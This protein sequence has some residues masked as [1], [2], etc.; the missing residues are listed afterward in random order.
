MSKIDREYYWNLPK[1][2]D[3]FT[4]L[5]P[6]ISGLVNTDVWN[7][8]AYDAS[9]FYKGVMLTSEV[10]FKSIIAERK[11]SVLIKRYSEYLQ[12][13]SLLE[14]EYSKN[15]VTNNI[16]S[17]K[18]II[19]QEELYLSQQ[20]SWLN[21]QNLRTNITWKDVRETL[22][23]NDVAIEFVSF[24]GL[25]TNSIHTYY[26]AYVINNKSLSPKLIPLFR[27][28]QLTKCMI[29][30][31]D[32]KGISD[33]IW[34]NEEMYDA[35]INAQN[36]YFSASGLLN[37]IA[38]EYLPIESNRYN[39]INER[40]NIYRLS[41]TREL[42]FRQKP[43]KYKNVYLYGG[44]DYN[45]RGN[46][47]QSNDTEETETI[48]L[49]RSVLESLVL[50][51][52]FEQLVGSEQEVKAIKQEMASKNVNCSVFTGKEGTEFSFK[53]KSG[54][55]INVLHFSTH[56]MFVSTEKDSIKNT[57]NFQFIINDDSIDDE[58]KSLSHSFLV[59]SGG[60]A[61]IHQDDIP[62]EQDDGILTA[63]EISHLF[64]PE[65]DLVVL[66]ACQTA[67]GELYDDGVYGLQRGFKKA[68]A[69]TILMSLDKVDDEATKVLMVE[70]YKNLMSGKT[71]LQSLKDAQK[72]LREYENGKYDD[73][74]FWAS[75]IMLDGLN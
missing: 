2:K 69:N 52:D 23:D 30:K 35:I 41:S 54:A 56:G 49:S 43:I 72:Y 48:G 25:L 66:S 51:G 59:M 27:E 58:A 38:I 55:P 17:L 26:Y 33:L 47:L 46:N 12:D 1:M 21:K 7:A 67:L 61:L 75:F 68:G 24:Q 28:D 37:V 19:Q 34:G 42:C 9:L 4:W 60:N 31:I 40:F 71:K 8:M 39:Y 53:E 50:R 64:F 14:Q 45:S 5:L 11:D 29:P 3:L 63:L 6:T 57:N 62:S 10:E 74:K 65:L 73:P 18:S 36:I 44:L 20:V 22:G 32:F 70:F 15:I 13:L 16:D